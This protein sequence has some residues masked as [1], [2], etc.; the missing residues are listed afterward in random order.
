MPASL[1]MRIFTRFLPFFPANPRLGG[2]AHAGSAAG[3]RTDESSEPGT[4][5]TPPVAAR[6]TCAGTREACRAT[7][8]IVTARSHQQ[9]VT[10]VS[11]TDTSPEFAVVLRRVLYDALNFLVVACLYMLV[12]VFFAFAVVVKAQG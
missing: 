9:A 11:I 7:S 1:T 2:S 6:P 8:D 12:G 3:R 4:G 5:R 10:E